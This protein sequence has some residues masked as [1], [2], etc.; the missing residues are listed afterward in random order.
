[1]F[2]NVGQRIKNYAKGLFI[3]QVVMYVIGGIVTLAV[4]DGEAGLVIAG[5]VMLGLGWA[6]AWL[7]SVFI[8]GFGELIVKAT[9]IARNT[10]NGE[11]KINENTV[12]TEAESEIVNEEKVPEKV[13][14]QWRC[15]K[16][17]YMTTQDPCP[18]CNAN[19][20]FKMRTGRDMW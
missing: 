10:S 1:M 15:E 20:L 6:I 17:G 18:I 8:Y 7:N 13:I 3:V 5:L 12:E 9:E 14:H 4:S 2:E 19:E 16:C 11:E